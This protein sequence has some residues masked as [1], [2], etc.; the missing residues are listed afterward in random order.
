M[1]SRQPRQP[2]SGRNPSSPS[3]PLSISERKLSANATVKVESNKRLPEPEAGAPA[4]RGPPQDPDA[5]SPPRYRENHARMWATFA[6]SWLGRSA[7]PWEAPGIR[8]SAA[9]T[10]R[11][12]RAS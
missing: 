4:G 1:G 6:I 9:G 7:M 3:I 2:V 8:T 11:S 5:A 10:F 12:L